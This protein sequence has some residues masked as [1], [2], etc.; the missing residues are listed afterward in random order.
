[1]KN[2]N[3]PDELPLAVGPQAASLRFI[4]RQA[5]SLRSD[6]ATYNFAL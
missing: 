1:M 6:A 3:S 2:N 5:G 4:H